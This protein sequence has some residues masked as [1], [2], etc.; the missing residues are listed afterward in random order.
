MDVAE[1]IL[2]NFGRTQETPHSK[3]F[4][5]SFAEDRENSS[6]SPLASRRE[7][8]HPVEV[9][10]EKQLPHASS[11]PKAN[12]HSEGID[13]ENKLEPPPWRPSI[14]QPDVVGRRHE[15]LAT[16]DIDSRATMWRANPEVIVVG[17]D[18][19]AGLG[20]GSSSSRSSRS[21]PN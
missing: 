8:S 2:G 19:W 5:P 17:G 7:K 1:L 14:K 4:Q 11:R 12:Y 3:G 13:Q 10:A 18:G 16:N 9:D 21:K 15:N 20:N 6:V